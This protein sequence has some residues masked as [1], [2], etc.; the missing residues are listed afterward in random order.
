MLNRKHTNVTRLKISVGKMGINNPMFGKLGDLS[1][2]YGKKH[3]NQ[4]LA[5]LSA[6]RKG[7]IMKEEI[8]AK[9]S[10]AKKGQ[11]IKKEETR[12]KMAAAKSGKNHPMFGKKHS[13]G[14]I[15]KISA[16]RL[17]YKHTLEARVRMSEAKL[18]SKHSEEAKVKMSEANKDKAQRIEVTDVLTR[19]ITTYS[20]MKAAARALG[21]K[22]TIISTY[23]RNK[24]VSPYK[25]QYLFK[26]SSR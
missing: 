15:A 22:H 4:T 16:A 18:G 14:T 6:V 24:Q 11:I 2:R 19:E 23:L 12:A 3:S 1:P 9:I 5:K 13:L 17:G 7:K 26:K 21:L 25:K 8:R 20:S 10:A